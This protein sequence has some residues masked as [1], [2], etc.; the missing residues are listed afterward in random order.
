MSQ[1]FKLEALFKLQF[2]ITAKRTRLLIP[3]LITSLILSLNTFAYNSNT[4]DSAAIT[5][6]KPVRI[7][8]ATRL[9]AEKPIIDGVLNDSCWKTG[10]WAGNFTQWIP[11]EG[12]KPSFP[13]YVKILYDNKK[14]YVAIRAVDNEPEKISKRAGR[15]DELPGDAAGI[16]FDSYDV[17][18][19]NNS[20]VDYSFNNPDFSFVQFR[21]NL[22][23][24]WEYRPG[25]QIYIVW[26]QDRTNFEQPGAENVNNTMGKIK[27]TFPNNIFLVKINYWF[28]L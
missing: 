22:V 13:A 6:K 2:M 20:I 11:N 15:R 17:S 10:E 8:N 23:F 5:N 12:A 18:E 28:S 4:D 14:I 25:S 26:L 7:Y 19:N 27:S 16:N 21:S 3:T 1:V 24:R 9:S